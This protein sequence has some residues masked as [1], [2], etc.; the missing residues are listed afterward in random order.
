ML[1][2]LPFPIVAGRLSLPPLQLTDP[3]TSNLY[4]CCGLNIIMS[5]YQREHYLHSPL[6]S[7]SSIRLVKL[8]PTSTQG[9]ICLELQ[10]FTLED[11]PPFDAL[12]YIWGDPSTIC[13]IRCNGCRMSVTQNLF[14]FLSYQRSEEPC[15]L[16]IDAISLDTSNLEEKNHTVPRIPQ[17]YSAANRTVCWIEIGNMRSLRTFVFSTPTARLCNDDLM[18]WFSMSNSYHTAHRITGRV[19]PRPDTEVRQLD[20][21]TWQDVEAFLDQAYFKR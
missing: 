2:L 8:L 7:R 9:S 11:A 17:I 13:Q 21:R 20:H 12:L 18:H 16:W 1:P 19:A 10:V 15:L 6:P 3:S 4:V 14:D 5:A